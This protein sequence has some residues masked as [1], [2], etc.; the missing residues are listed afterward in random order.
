MILYKLSHQVMK[1]V[2]GEAGGERKREREGR[3]GEGGDQTDF[4]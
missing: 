1:E 2:K 4:F 3:E